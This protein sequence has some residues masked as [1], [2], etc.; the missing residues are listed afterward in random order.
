MG[1]SA[2][3]KN[4]AKSREK[5]YLQ[6]GCFSLARAKAVTRI[7]QVADHFSQ[8]SDQVQLRAVTQVEAEIRTL[9]PHEDSRFTEIREKMLTL[10]SQ[11]Q[12]L[13]RHAS[14]SISLS[15]A[16]HERTARSQTRDRGTQLS[17]F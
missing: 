16:H 1:A 4:F 14:T 2:T 6:Y 10:L 13:T 7:N 3:L 8:C 15:Q 5:A 17:A 9:L 12:E 11:A